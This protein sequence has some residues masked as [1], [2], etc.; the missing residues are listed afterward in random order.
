M[1]KKIW[2]SQLDLLVE[3]SDQIRVDAYQEKYYNLYQLLGATL[4]L[5]EQVDGHAH[6]VEILERW[7]REYDER[8][9]TPAA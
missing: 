3:I 8:F 4:A 9:G 1:S 6:V 5:C 7:I 2:D